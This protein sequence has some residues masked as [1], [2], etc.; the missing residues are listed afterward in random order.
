MI[1]SIVVVSALALASACATDLGPYCPQ[2]GADEGLSVWID[3]AGVLPPDFY[4]ISVFAD[5]QV[6]S[7]TGAIQVGDP[8]YGHHSVIASATSTTPDGKH[9]EVLAGLDS[10]T[11]SAEVW[12]DEGGGPAQVSIEISNSTGVIAHADFTPTYRLFEPNGPDCPP[13][14]HVALGSMTITLFHHASS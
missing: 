4:T 9:L 12:Y 11:G 3:V 13:H 2:A 6:R 10:T 14:A 5:G 1:R 7:T 8:G